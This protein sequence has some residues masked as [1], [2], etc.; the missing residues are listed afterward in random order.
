MWKLIIPIL[1]YLDVLNEDTGSSKS[2]RIYYESTPGL[3]P[4]DGLAMIRQE[5]LMKMDAFLLAS[6]IAVSGKN[7]C[8]ITIYS[9]RKQ[10]R[11]KIME[12][13]RFF[14]NLQKS[15]KELIFLLWWSPTLKILSSSAPRLLIITAKRTCSWLVH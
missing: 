13:R 15:Q 9:R 4:S 11:R 10:W 8:L 3:N 1:G 7:S 14:A 6:Y 2:L 5:D 12:M